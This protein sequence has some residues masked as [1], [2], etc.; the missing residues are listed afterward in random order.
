MQDGQLGRVVRALR[1]RRGWRQSDV[2]ARSGVSRAT[3]S[4][5][6]RGHLESVSLAALRPLP[7]CPRGTPADCAALGGADLDRL[8]DERHSRLQAF[9]KHRL[10]RWGWVA[11]P[12]VSFSRYGDRGRIDLLAWNPARRILLVIEI[13]TQIVDIQGLLGPLDVKLRLAPGIARERGWGHPAGVVPL[14]VVAESSTNRRRIASRAPLF[15]Q[16]GLRGRRA[17]TWLRR[18]ESPATGLLVLTGLSPARASSTRRLPTSRP[19]R[20]QHP[21]VVESP[22]GT[23]RVGS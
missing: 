6:E 17:I 4:V 8:L 3:V 2:A 16:L 7:W 15:R 9:W 10:E 13:K 18:P 20:A 5:I 21:L 22:R 12:E 14:L 19:P 1:R 11:L 23:A